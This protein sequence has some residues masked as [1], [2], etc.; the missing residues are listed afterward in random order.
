MYLEMDYNKLS[1]IFVN[2]LLETNREI[3]RAHV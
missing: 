3:G 1:E 2:N